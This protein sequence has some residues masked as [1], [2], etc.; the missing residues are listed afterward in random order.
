MTNNDNNPSEAGAVAPAKK[1]KNKLAIILI[2]FAVLAVGVVIYSMIHAGEESTDDAMLEAQVVSMAPRV[3]GYIKKLNIRDNEI[4]KQGA[5][6]AQI[7]PYEYQTALQ[8]AVGAAQAAQAELDR[9]QKEFER[10]NELDNKARSGQALDNAKAA[11]DAALANRAIANADMAQAQKNLNDTRIIAPMDGK[12]TERTIEQGDYVQ[13]GQR[14]FS[15]V[16]TDLWVVANYKETQIT[17]MKIGQRVDI[18]VD[19]YPDAD[20]SGKVESIQAG[21]GA[22]FSLFPPQNA[23]GNFVKIVQRVP[24]KITLDKQRY[25]DVT[26]APGLSVVPTV[27]TK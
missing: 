14:I 1:T 20:L 25:E 9:T 22:R 5:V 8:S 16:G 6:L 12:I 17:K 24:V 13:P 15:L 11:L 10:L 27:H 7:D 3:S 26:L 2:V 18:D 21:T 4:V 23:T 19:A